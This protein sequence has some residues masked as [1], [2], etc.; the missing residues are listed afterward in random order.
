MA[1]PNDRGDEDVWFRRGVRNGRRKR[2][3]GR[4]NV[5]GATAA[6]VPEAHAVPR[7]ARAHTVYLRPCTESG[8]TE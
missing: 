3:P 5:L 8:G 6:R 4:Q 2:G 7:L 1:D